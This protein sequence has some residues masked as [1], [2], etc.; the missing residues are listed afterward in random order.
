MCVHKLYDFK[1][2][3]RQPEA[4][5]AIT[6]FG[7]R[8]P[9]LQTR[10]SWGTAWEELFL[11]WNRP[12]TAA[13]ANLVNK[14]F[15]KE[16]FFLCYCPA[17]RVTS[18]EFV[19]NKFSLMKIERL[20]VKELCRERWKIKFYKIIIF[21]YKIFILRLHSSS[22]RSNFPQYARKM[23]FGNNWNNQNFS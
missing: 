11:F 17:H 14:N 6:S 2:R 8:V 20:K 12:I 5:T 21:W 1:D 23:C 9:R 7:W 4:I 10:I 16:R 15:S 13:I 3:I 22:T 19:Q 18:F